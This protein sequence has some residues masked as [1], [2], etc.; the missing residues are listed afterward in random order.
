MKVS[1]ILNV[2]TGLDPSMEVRVADW[3]FHYAVSIAVIAPAR[4]GDVLYLGK[5]KESDYLLGVAAETFTWNDWD[6]ETP[7]K[8]YK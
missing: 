1:E 4:D 7:E 3:P 6:N 5:A 2:L 8:L